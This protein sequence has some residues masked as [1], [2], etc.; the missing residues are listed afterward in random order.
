M[1]LLSSVPLGFRI[2]GRV[3]RQFDLG[4]DPMFKDPSRFDGDSIIDFPEDRS[5]SLVIEDGLQ[6]WAPVLLLQNQ[7]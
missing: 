1:K 2:G 3:E 6:V 5:T 4:D 7:G